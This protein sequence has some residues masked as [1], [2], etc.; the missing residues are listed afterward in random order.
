[1]NKEIPRIEGEIKKCEG[2]LVNAN[3]VYHAPAAVVEQERHRLADW[4]NQIDALRGQAERLS[5]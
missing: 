3:F 4:N 1:L 5:G 2:K